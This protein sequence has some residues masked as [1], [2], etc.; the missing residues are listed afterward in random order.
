MSH[1]VFGASEAMRLVERFTR[2]DGRTLDY[3]FTVTDPTT[4]AEPWTASIPM[5][6]TDHPILEYACHEGN[7]SMENML[8]GARVQEQE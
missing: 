8:R 5:T 4:F 2:L 6:A 7:Y 3:R 1:T